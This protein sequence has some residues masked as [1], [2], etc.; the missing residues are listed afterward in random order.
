MY[1]YE[2][3]KRKKKGDIKMLNDKKSKREQKKNF[4]TILFQVVERRKITK[5]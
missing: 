1:V 5:P 4:L 3:Q 2:N